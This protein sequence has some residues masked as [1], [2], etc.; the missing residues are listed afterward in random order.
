M[1]MPWRTPACPSTGAGS[2]APSQ[3][4]PRPSRHTLMQ[5]ASTAS[6]WVGG[7]PRGWAGGQ[8]GR[9]GG[10]FGGWNVG[11]KEG[12]QHMLM[13]VQ[14]GVRRGLVVACAVE[15]CGGV[16]H[17]Q[18][19][20]QASLPSLLHAKCMLSF[21]GVQPSRAQIP[22]L[23]AKSSSS[24]ANSVSKHCCFSMYPPGVGP[25]E[26][27]QCLSAAG[28]VPHQAQQGSRHQAGQGSSQ[29]GQGPTPERSAGAAACSSGGGSA[30]VQH[31][32][33]MLGCNRSTKP[34]CI[35][36]FAVP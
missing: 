26:G 31:S 9:Q 36:V 21:G 22:A 29:A 3:A 30:A 7:H 33:G 11:S 27:C 34:S 5:H 10:R 4:C 13:H 24:T 25:A 2:C 15:A 23:Y 12:A 32:Q 18:R 1:L 19:S 35:R 6:R 20:F 8:V 17:G 14:Q 16:R 28:P